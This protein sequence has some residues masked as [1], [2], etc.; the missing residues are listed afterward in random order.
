MKNEEDE[1]P[2]ISAE[3]LETKS[4]EE[5]LPLVYDELRQIARWRMSREKPGQT[6]QA[7]ALVHEAFQR[8]S[9]GDTDKKWGNRR[10]F[11]AAASE[12]MRR[13]LIENAR[14]K[15]AE[16]RGGGSAHTELAESRIIAPAPDNE[17]LDLDEALGKLAEADPQSAE[18]V[19]LRFF[20][21][22]TQT[23]CAEVMGMSRRDADRVWAFARIWLKTEME[24][25]R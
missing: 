8:I 24:K 11:F 13:I 20:I 3:D 9:G 17:I 1:H 14:K 16:K 15:N 5:L 10:H 21:G 7:T 25:E 6:L 4:T 2:S 19:K 12:A 23:E 22:L 18:L